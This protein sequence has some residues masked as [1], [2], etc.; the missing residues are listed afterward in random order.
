MSFFDLS[1]A[2]RD[3]L[4][5]ELGRVYHGFDEETREL[6]PPRSSCAGCGRCCIGPPLYMTLSDLEYA[7]ATRALEE[8]NRSLPVHFEEAAPDRRLAFSSWTCPFYSHAEGCTVYENRPLACRVFGKYARARIE[9]AF[10]GYQ[11]VAIPYQRPEELPAWSAFRALLARY[12]ARRG[13]VYPDALPYP[14]PTVELLLGMS[15]PWSPMAN[16]RLDLG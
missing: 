13:Y 7:Y 5:A 3:A 4:L 12:P 15:L 6:P 16:L 14:R 10:C 11:E 8:K 9:W 2:T 1:P